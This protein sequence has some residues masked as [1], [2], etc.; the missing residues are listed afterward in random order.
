MNNHV[1]L[2]L[3]SGFD[4]DPELPVSWFEAN[5]ARVEQGS[6]VECA[7]RLGKRGI[8]VLTPAS[9]SLILET[10]LPR[11]NRRRLLKV[12]PW[13]L[14]EQFACDVDSLHVATASQPE[15]ERIGVAVTDR[16]LLRSWLTRLRQA[17]ISP[18]ALTPESLMLPWGPGDWALSLDERTATLRSGRFQV[19][20]LPLGELPAL[21]ERTLAD[22][23]ESARPARRLVCIA[24]DGSAEALA[25]AAAFCAEQGL[26]F[27]HLDK[28]QPR[29]LLAPPGRGEP[30]IN[31]LQGEFRRDQP[32]RQ[33]LRPWWPVLALGLGLAALLLAGLA[34]EVATLR[35]QDALLQG[36]IEQVYRD[37]FPSSRNLVDPRFQMQQQLAALQSDGGSSRFLQLLAPAAAALA[38]APDTSLLALRYGEGRL[39]LELEVRD[40]AQLDALRVALATAA[41]IP[42][43]ILSSAAEDGRVRGRLSLGAG[44]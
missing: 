8:W 32:A 1:Y 31:L 17:G 37:T 25:Q 22:E 41:A 11:R 29:D 35:R 28:A 20:S 23:S 12:L 40:F 33:Y 43:T 44:A 26:E 2:R 15:G 3:P 13:T 36:Q 16:S 19:A 42:V 10:G 7:R 27:R 4:L 18:L 5:S 34:L 24:T 21:L 30:G 9:D 14:E 38:A 6:L 39:E